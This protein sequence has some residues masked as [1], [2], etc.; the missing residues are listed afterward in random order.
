MGSDASHVWVSVFLPGW[1]WVDIDPTNDQMLGPS[2]VTTAWGRYYGDVSPLRG[3]V[4][5]G[6]GLHRLHVSVKVEAIEGQARQ[7]FQA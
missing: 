2:Y 3:S 5:G 1:G 4:E 6:G 7:A